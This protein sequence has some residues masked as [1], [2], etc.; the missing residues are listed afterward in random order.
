MSSKWTSPGLTFTVTVLVGWVVWA[1]SQLASAE[2]AAK[3]KTDL[4]LS[5]FLSGITLTS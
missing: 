3:S 1:A 4:D 2:T 5:S